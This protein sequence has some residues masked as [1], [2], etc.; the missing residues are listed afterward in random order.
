MFEGLGN[1]VHLLAAV[2]WIG[3]LGIV[4]LGVRPALTRSIPDDAERARLLAAVHR[5]LV[6]LA[7]VAAVVLAAS[8]LMMMVTDDRF[9][10]FG[11]WP[12]AWSKLLA[13]KHALFLG[14][15]AILLTMRRPRAASSERD[16]V[17]LSLWIGIA[18]LVV[19]GLLTASG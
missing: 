18:V 16:L 11:R 4:V 19:T 15:V 14:L 7:A 17:D 12:N 2:L 3:G 8:G 1:A 13:A 5:R 9:E 10:G 6:R